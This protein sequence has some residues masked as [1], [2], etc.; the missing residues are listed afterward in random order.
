MDTFSALGLSREVLR[1]LGEMGSDGPTPVQARAIPC[2]LQG[3][4]VVAQAL[5][6]AGE[7]AAY[8]WSRSTAVSPTIA[9]LRAL[10]RGVHAIVATPGRLPDHP[11]RG[12]AGLGAVRLV[13]LDEPTRCWTWALRTT[14]R[15]S[16]ATCLPN[17]PRPCSRRPC[18][19]RSRT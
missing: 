12:S 18:P 7:T 16:S 17:E 1:S 6:G 10:G 13:V 19:G 3:R 11:R 2:L 8:S 14:S 4:D 15:P 9:S 5:T